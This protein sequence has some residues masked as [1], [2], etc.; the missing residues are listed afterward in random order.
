MEIAEWAHTMCILWEKKL[1]MHIH[2]TLLHATSLI[3]QV[4]CELCCLCSYHHKLSG[5]ARWDDYET[6]PGK[7]GAGTCILE[8]SRDSAANSTL[9]W[10]AMYLA[11]ASSRNCG[12]Q[13]R[14]SCTHRYSWGQT[15]AF[16]VVSHSS[17]KI[18]GSICLCNSSW[19]CCLM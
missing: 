8:G 4:V 9:C 7:H 12:W 10:I 1:H 2:D 17:S 6:Q 16:V 14:Q 19:Q 5:S 15:S 3:M 18:N 13:V 11:A